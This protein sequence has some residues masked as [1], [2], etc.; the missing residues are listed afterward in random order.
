MLFVLVLH[1]V[2]C[3]GDM[4]FSWFRCDTQGKVGS[5][6]SQVI[7]DTHNYRLLGICKNIPPFLAKTVN[8]SWEQQTLFFPMHLV[9][10]SLVLQVKF[11]F[12]KI[13]KTSFVPSLSFMVWGLAW[14]SSG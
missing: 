14:L 4:I 10:E 2:G 6:A 1:V 8:T 3:V 5:V 7:S 9:I 13:E 11:G 12:S